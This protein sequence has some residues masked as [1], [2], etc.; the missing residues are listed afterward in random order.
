[1]SLTLTVKGVIADEDC[2]VIRYILPDKRTNIHAYATWT[3]VTTKRD[4][5]NFLRDYYLKTCIRP[6]VEYLLNIGK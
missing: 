4:S 1:M 2:M 6:N 5:R 3:Q